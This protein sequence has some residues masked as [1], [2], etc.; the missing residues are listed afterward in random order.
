MQSTDGRIMR[1]EIAPCLKNAATLQYGFTSKTRGKYVAIL[2]VP[3]LFKC[4]YLQL[5][6]MICA[7][8]WY[9]FV[10]Q[11]ASP[12]LV[13]HHPKLRGYH[14]EGLPVHFTRLCQ[15]IPGNDTQ[16]VAQRCPAESNCQQN[17]RGATVGS[18]G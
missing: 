16:V 15:E 5:L 17:Q 2:I 4:Q 3:L 14:Y 9:S 6:L 10:L 11:L 13:P 8:I 12:D 7:N 1:R 18:G